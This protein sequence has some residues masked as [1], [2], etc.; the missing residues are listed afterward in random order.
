M[1]N[2]C[3][4]VWGE[5]S[6]TFVAIRNEKRQVNSVQPQ[7]GLALQEMLFCKVTTG[8]LGLAIGKSGCLWQ[9]LIL[10]SH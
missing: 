2:S 5:A 9:R 3:F 4:M 7:C 8:V 1:G 6:S 10:V